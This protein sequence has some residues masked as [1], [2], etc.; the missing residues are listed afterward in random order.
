MNTMSTQHFFNEIYEAATEY[1]TFWNH[2]ASY[3]SDVWR[4]NDDFNENNNVYVSQIDA[5][6]VLPPWGGVDIFQDTLP[7]AGSLVTGTFVNGTFI[8]EYERSTPV[9]RTQGCREFLSESRLNV[10]YL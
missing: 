3:K 6:L 8:P 4:D 1:W 5:S 10:D 7:K 9:E 2:N